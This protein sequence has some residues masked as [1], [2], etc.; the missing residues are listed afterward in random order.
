M[1]RVCV[2]CGSKSGDRAEYA[3][4]AEQLGRWLARGGHT[5]I[6]GGGSTGIMARRYPQN[7]V[8]AMHF[9]CR[10]AGNP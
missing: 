5:L 3:E 1:L 2:F 7:G 10:N 6:Y 8:F 4:S 9:R